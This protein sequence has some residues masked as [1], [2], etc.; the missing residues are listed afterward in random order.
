MSTTPVETVGAF[1]KRYGPGR[2]PGAHRPAV[3]TGYALA[4]AALTAALAFLA[5]T[6]VPRLLFGGPVAVTGGLVYFGLLAIPLVVPAA[7]V[8]GVAAERL[9]PTTTPYRGPVVGLVATLLTYVVATALIPLLMV[10]STI[11][12]PN[13]FITVGNAVGV[14]LLFGAFGFVYTFWVTLPV[15]AVSGWVHDRA[16]AGE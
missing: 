8:G 1:C 2:L 11:P 10:A 12:E 16:V 14:S 13:T 7:F 5:V 9:L 4:T 15:G 3:G 6:G